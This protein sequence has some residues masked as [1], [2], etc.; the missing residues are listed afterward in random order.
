MSESVLA[1]SRTGWDIAIGA[2]LVVGGLIVL[3]HAVIATT[4]SILF[5]GWMLVLFGVLGLVGSLFRIGKGGFWTTALSGALLTVLGVVMLRNVEAAAV[6]LTLVAG[7][8]FL[9]SGIV[10][11]VAAGGLPEYRIAL[12]LSGIVSTVLGLLVL[13]NLFE[14][15][16]V[17]LGVYL[18]V[19]M[20]AD[21]IAMML[22]GRVRLMPAYGGA[23]HGL[24]AH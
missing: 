24:P 15:S 2:L 16:F 4:V 5:I 1:R 11:L 3:G 19:E 17:L 12:I 18:G 9:T 14:A 7:A 23:Q 22:V 6:T 10:R 13:F 21:G 8:I 20:L